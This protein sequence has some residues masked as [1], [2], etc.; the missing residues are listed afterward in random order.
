MQAHTARLDHRTDRDEP[1]RGVPT[2]IT[3]RMD[4]RSKGSGHQTGAIAG[5]PPGDIHQHRGRPFHRASQHR[6]AITTERHFQPRALR[7]P[8]TSVASTGMT[9]AILQAQ[10]PRATASIHDPTM[11]VG[12]GAT[13]IMEGTPTAGGGK[14]A[15]HGRLPGNSRSHRLNGIVIVKD[16]I[17]AIRSAKGTCTG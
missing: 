15:S 2:P 8:E 16:R 10:L 11:D 14:Q 1:H 17:R 5:T 7:Y 6:T 4:D 9:G 12:I 3:G 13:G